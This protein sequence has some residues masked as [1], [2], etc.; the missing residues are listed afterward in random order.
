MRTYKKRTLKNYVKGGD[1]DES[2]CMDTI[3]HE[4][5]MEETYEKGKKIFEDL[6][7][8]L[9][10]KIEKNKELKPEEKKNN[11][12]FL[13][14]MKKMVKKMNNTTHKKKVIKLSRDTCKQIYCNKGCLGTLFEEGDPNKLPAEFAKKFKGNKIL[15]NKVNNC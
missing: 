4:K 10:K 2:K 12:K 6:A 5:K 15:N 14:N 11:E 7:I 1:E 13:K 8:E 9:E 3:C